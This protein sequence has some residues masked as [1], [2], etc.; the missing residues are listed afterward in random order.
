MR[1]HGMG[2]MLPW[3]GR[4][5]SRRV[6]DN[7][8]RQTGAALGGR[9]KAAWEWGAVLGQVEFYGWNTLDIWYRPAPPCSESDNGEVSN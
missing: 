4:Q 6:P 8:R 2:I 1:T 3:H 9:L 7:D 5:W